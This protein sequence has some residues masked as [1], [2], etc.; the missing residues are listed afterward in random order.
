VTFVYVAPAAVLT[1]RLLSP[2]EYRLY[3]RRTRSFPE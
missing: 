1:V 3:S 2:T